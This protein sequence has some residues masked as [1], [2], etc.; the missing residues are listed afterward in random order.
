MRCCC[1]KCHFLRERGYDPK[2]GEKKDPIACEPEPV[3]DN[4]VGK[5]PEGH[6]YQVQPYRYDLGHGSSS[7]QGTVYQIVLCKTMANSKSEQ[8]ADTIVAQLN[9]ARRL[10]RD[11]KRLKSTVDQL[12]KCTLSTEDVYQAMVKEVRDLPH[13]RWSSHRKQIVDFGKGVLRRLGRHT[14]INID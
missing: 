4:G 6:Y 10:E 7:R 12:N 3:C 13:C 2:H 8:D 5:I 14:S 1:S 11:V 9:R